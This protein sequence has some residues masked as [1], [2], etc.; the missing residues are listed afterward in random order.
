MRFVILFGFGCM[1]INGTVFGGG[2]T[3]EELGM[4]LHPPPPPDRYK[5]VPETDAGGNI[6]MHPRIS[7]AA[8]LQSGATIKHDP[9]INRKL[10]EERIAEA[11]KRR[12]SKKLL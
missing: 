9:E 5:M 12:R 2:P 7:E 6:T 3:N 8:R 10:R 1:F 11:K 4:Q